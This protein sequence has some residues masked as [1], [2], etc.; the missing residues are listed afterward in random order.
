MYPSDRFCF[1]KTGPAFFWHKLPTSIRKRI[2]AL[3]PCLGTGSVKQV[4]RAKLMSKGVEEEVAVAI[5]RN[6]VED[7]ALSSLEALES[8]P[9]LEA[10]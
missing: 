6:Q 9:D 5:L 10:V 8:S 7:E 4:H 3:G 1:L 2:A